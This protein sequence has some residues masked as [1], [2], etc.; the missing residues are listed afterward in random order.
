MLSYKQADISFSLTAIDELRDMR[1][2]VRQENSRMKTEIISE[3]IE[4]MGE[5]FTRH[6]FP[7]LDNHKTRLIALENH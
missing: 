6:V 5:I 2:F 7:T 3:I 1:D 4:G